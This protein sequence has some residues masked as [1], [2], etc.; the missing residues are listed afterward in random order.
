MPTQG[1]ANSGANKH[2]PHGTSRPRLADAPSPASAA[3]PQRSLWPPALTHRLVHD[4]LKP[5]HYLPVGRMEVPVTTCGRQTRVARSTP[6][7]LPH[8]QVLGVE[9][10]TPA[11]QRRVLLTYGLHLHKPHGTQTLD[12]PHA[13][14]LWG[15]VRVGGMAVR[16]PGQAKDL[17]LP[18]GGGASGCPRR[19]RGHLGRH[20]SDAM[21]S[22]WWTGTHQGARRPQEPHLHAGGWGN[23]L[24]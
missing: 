14:G 24:P 8:F 7:A 10:L 5:V 21:G 2:Q 17:C 22:P 23:V 15:N 12:A 11:P 3:P 9:R 13:Q 6:Q 20:L 19:A 18:G 4:P 16:S 1:L